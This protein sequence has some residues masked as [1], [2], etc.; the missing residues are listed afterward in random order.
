[1]TWKSDGMEKGLSVSDYLKENK[2][3]E[4]VIPDYE[5]NS[6]ITKALDEVV[7]KW[8]GKIDISIIIL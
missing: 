1:M 6:G 5:L 8:K 3:L 7:N 4:I 2:V